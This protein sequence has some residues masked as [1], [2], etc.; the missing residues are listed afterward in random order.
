MVPYTDKR[1]AIEIATRFLTQ[2]FSVHSIDAVLERDVWVVTAR[3]GMFN[4]IM[5]EKVRIDSVTGRITD[6][7]MLNA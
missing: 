2:H 6:Y 7:M 4:K 3:I 5:L 1:T